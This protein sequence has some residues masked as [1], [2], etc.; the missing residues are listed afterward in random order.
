M[1]AEKQGPIGLPVLALMEV[2]VGFSST[3]AKLDSSS[4][5]KL[6]VVTLP[7]AHLPC[8]CKATVINS[9]LAVVHSQ[10]CLV[11]SAEAAVELA[12]PLRIGTGLKNTQGD[13]S[14]ID[15]GGGLGGGL[16][17]D[18]GLLESNVGPGCLLPLELPPLSECKAQV[19]QVPNPQQQSRK[20]PKLR[21]SYA[22]APPTKLIS[23]ATNKLVIFERTNGLFSTGLNDFWGLVV[24]V[25]RLVGNSPINTRQREQRAESRE[26]AHTKKQRQRW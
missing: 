18:A 26:Q 7:Q 25:F 4:S 19:P 9:A 15:I 11:V 3:P 14:G 22:A 23:T 16:V 13:K 17:V 20:L 1:Q 6:A 21:L 12:L 10:P 2:H 5:L 24:W 8:P